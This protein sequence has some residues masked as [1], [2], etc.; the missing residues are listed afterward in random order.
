MVDTSQVKTGKICRQLL[1]LKSWET[2]E[3]SPSLQ[4]PRVWIWRAISKEKKY[5]LNQLEVCMANQLWKQ[6]MASFFK[7]QPN[8][9]KI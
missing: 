1:S 5:H 9:I 2:A 3:S 8:S 4:Q 7:Y 6:G